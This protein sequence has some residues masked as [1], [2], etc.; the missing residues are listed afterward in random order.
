[1]KIAVLTL[2]AYETNCYLVWD[3]ERRCSVVIDPG[4]DEPALTQALDREGLRPDAVLLTHGHFDHVGA[5]ETLRARGAE[6]WLC[7]DDLQLGS[8]T[9]LNPNAD[10]R[11]FDEG[12]VV[13]IGTLR[14]QVL[15]TP[16]HTPGSCCL[17]IADVLFTGDTLFAGSC[18]RVDFPG[19][20]AEQMTASL[21]RLYELPGDFT[22]L[23]GHGG[24]STLSLERR[25]NPYLRQA[26]TG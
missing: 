17:Q 10:Y 25:T 5:V 22:V 14:F 11:F 4:Y 26:V 1:M 18:G 16:G 12:D 15:R 19:G 23:T 2:G 13:Q 3:E 8:M 20:S 9:T 7:A 21:N 6:V 24:S